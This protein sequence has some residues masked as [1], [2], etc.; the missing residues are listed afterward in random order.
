MFS[1]F[2][3]K[4]RDETKPHVHITR[5]ATEDISNP[6]EVPMMRGGK[7]II[8]RMLRSSSDEMVGRTGRTASAQR[9]LDHDRG[10]EGLLEKQERKGNG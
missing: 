7:N 4:D 10:E 2:L 5:S 8:P 1:Y 6:G 3:S 9:P